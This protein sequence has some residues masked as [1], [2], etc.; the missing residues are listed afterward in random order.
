MSDDVSSAWIPVRVLLVSNQPIL[1]EAVSQALQQSPYTIGTAQTDGEAIA[2]LAAWQPHLTIVDIDFANGDFLDWLQETG[3]DSAPVP[4]VALTRR[5]NLT[6]KLLAF[7]RGVDDILVVPFFPEEL[8]ARVRVVI[9]RTMRSP[10]LPTAILRLGELEIDVQNRSVRVGGDVLHL[11]ALDQ[12]LLLF[13]VAN[14]GR[15]VTRD[16]ILD[17][18]WGAEFAAESNLVDRHIRNLRVKLRDDWHRPRYIATV[19]GWGYRF[20]LTTAMDVHALPREADAHH[21]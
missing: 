18:M 17:H 6:T 8:L 4:V 5:V 12:S 10:S 21:P 15:V 14:A 1:I 20:L 11:T 7:D 13:L 3:Q 16:E 9:R 19:P 2:L